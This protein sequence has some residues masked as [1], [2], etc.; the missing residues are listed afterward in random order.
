MEERRCPNWQRRRSQKPL[1]ESACGFDPHPPHVAHSR[2]VVETVR[3]MAK[4][5]LTASAIARRTGVARSTIREW[6]ANPARAPLGRRHV[7]LWSAGIRRDGRPGRRLRVRARDVP[8]R[9]IDRPARPRGLPAASDTRQPIPAN[10]RRMPPTHRECH[11]RAACERVSTARRERVRREL[12]LEALAVPPAS[13]QFGPQALGPIRLEAW[14]DRIV[15]AHADQ[16]VRGFIHSDG[17]RHLNRVNGRQ[18]PRY[19]FTNQSA[20]IR[21][22][23]SRACDRLGVRWTQSYW[24]TISIARAQSVEL[25]DSFVG[26]KA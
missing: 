2:D 5:G 18:Y 25:L 21:E 16:L 22:I 13:A 20:D 26:P 23:F 11:A 9:R 10:R 4:E 1:R 19:M 7:S 14:Q 3:R 12:L 24:K 6:S 8:R 17:T 15:A